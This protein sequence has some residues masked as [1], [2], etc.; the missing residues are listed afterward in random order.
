MEETKVPAPQ[1]IDGI[2]LGIKFKLNQVLKN[3]FLL[4]D[5]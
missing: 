1:K 4:R 2:F 5:V 3:E